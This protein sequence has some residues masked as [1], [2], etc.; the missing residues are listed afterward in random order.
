MTILKPSDIA[1][2]SPVTRQE[3]NNLALSSEN[4]YAFY[5]SPAWWEY[6]T[7]VTLKDY[8]LRL[9]PGENPVI[10]QVCDNDGKLAGVSGVL[11]TDYVLHFKLK[12]R[13]LAHCNIPVAKL[14]GGPPLIGDDENLYVEF[15]KSI[16]EAFP[17]CSAIHIPW[18]L[19]N[20]RSWKVLNTSEKLRRYAGVYVPDK[21]FAKH[22]SIVLNQTFEEYLHKF[23][24]KIRYN[25][26][27]DIKVLTDLCNGQ[28]S[29]VRIE[30]AQDVKMFLDGAFTVSSRSWQNT[31]E[32][33]MDNSPEECERYERFANQGVL[34]CYLLKCGETPCAFVRGFQFGDMFYY[35]RTGFDQDL[36]RFSPGR[37]VFYLMLEDLYAY[38]PPKRLNFQ[39]GDYEH[40]RRFSTECVEKADVLLVRKNA[41]IPSQLF[42][43]AHKLLGW[44]I[45]LAKRLLQKD[46]IVSEKITTEQ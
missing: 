26:K 9:H 46:T 38:R 37:A 42:L 3:W 5:Q 43:S 11:V 4:I 10:A 14:I 18:V 40:K 2:S 25:L 29:L 24:K 19:T 30:R 12:S 23:N 17:G 21:D 33:Q 13:S 8:I 41:D 32:P 6:S 36:S 44:S 45:S 1:A 22:Y 20:S 31:L 27:R 34:R 28:L 16:L 7:K 15:V 35:S 39:E